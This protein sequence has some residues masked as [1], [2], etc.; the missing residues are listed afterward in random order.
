MFWELSGDIRSGTAGSLLDTAVNAIKAGDK[1][2]AAAASEA[3]N[4]A[5]NNIEK[6][7]QEIQLAHQP[8]Q[9]KKDSRESWN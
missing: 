3:Y 2:A 9:N 4:T 7:L 6:L 5:S 8:Q 1:D